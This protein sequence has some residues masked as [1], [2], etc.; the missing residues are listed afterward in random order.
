VVAPFGRSSGLQTGTKL[1]PAGSDAAGADACSGSGAASTDTAHVQRVPWLFFQPQNNC[2]A[3]RSHTDKRMP[4][5]ALPPG[6]EV[7]RTRQA[8]TALTLLLSGAAED[9]LMP[10]RAEGRSAAAASCAERPVAGC[11]C[12]GHPAH[13]SLLQGRLCTRRALW[14]GERHPERAGRL[15]GVMFCEPGVSQGLP[16]AGAIANLDGRSLMNWPA[17]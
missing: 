3:L 16:G 6:P 17:G 7:Q 11:A 8:P 9:G 15:V 5:K 10:P 13:R 12:C 2:L 4:R 14:Q 1:P